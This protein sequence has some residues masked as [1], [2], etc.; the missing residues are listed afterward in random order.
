MCE[1]GLWACLCSHQIQ[2][3]RCLMAV[4]TGS[5][6][7]HQ[8]H[9]NLW[10]SIFSKSCWASDCKSELRKSAGSALMTL[11]VGFLVCILHFVLHYKNTNKSGVIVRPKP[12][13]FLSFSSTSTICVFT[14]EG[15]RCNN[16][17]WREEWAYPTLSTKNIFPKRFCKDEQQPYCSIMVPFINHQSSQHFLLWC[18]VK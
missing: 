12:F 3:P 5:S 11:P 16:F 14:P 13:S 15:K 2:Q 4:S 6:P 8:T 1:W 18:K 17:W 10:I 7:F 9:G